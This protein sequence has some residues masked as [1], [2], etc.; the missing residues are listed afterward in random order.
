MLASKLM[1]QPCFDDYLYVD[2]HTPLDADEASTSM[3]ST[4]KL[5]SVP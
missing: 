5:F 4:T 3:T 2:K 1:F